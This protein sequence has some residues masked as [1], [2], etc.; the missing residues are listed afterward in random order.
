MIIYEHVSLS[1]LSQ[2]Q[3][4]VAR[5]NVSEGRF[6]LI[7]ISIGCRSIGEDHFIRHGQDVVGIEGEAV[8]AGSGYFETADTETVGAFYRHEA[9]FRQRVF[10]RAK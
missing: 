5:E 6:R 2:R 3:A 8:L 4:R 10:R 9:A 7:F 1:Y